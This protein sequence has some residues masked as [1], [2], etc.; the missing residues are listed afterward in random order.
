MEKRFFWIGTGILL[1]VVLA[2]AIALIIKNANQPFHGSFLNPP[3]PA[4]DFTLTSQTGSPVSL[5][6]YRGKYVLL[7]FGY[8][9]CTEECPVTMALLAKARS[10]LGARAGQIQVMFV[11]TD[12]SGD[13]P[14][15]MGEFLGRFDP[16]FIGAT[17]TL[18]Q[19]QPIWKAYG[20]SVLD[21]GVTH[22]TYTYVIDPAGNLRLTFSAPFT[23]EE[24]AADLKLL[25][26]KN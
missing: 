3:A 2:A 1:L 21:G 19:L 23:A 6:E 7:Y 14:Q 12:P 16:N 8:S 4:S 10:E 9:H 17:G 20:V 24:V 22:S 26:G 11:S 5:S 13:T 15:S 25:V 18:A